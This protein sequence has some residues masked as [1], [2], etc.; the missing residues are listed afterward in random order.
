MI[1]WGANYSKTAY[2]GFSA[3]RRMMQA[4]GASLGE[5]GLAWGVDSARVR[6]NGLGRSRGAALLTQAGAGRGTRQ[7]LSSQEQSK[8][9][10]GPGFS[11]PL[12][13]VDCPRGT[14]PAA[15]APPRR[16]R[17]GCQALPPRWLRWGRRGWAVGAG[18]RSENTRHRD[19]H[20]KGRDGPDW[21]AAGAGGRGRPGGGEGP[22]PRR[23]QRAEEAGPARV[24]PAV[25]VGTV[26]GRG[27]VPVGRAGGTGLCPLCYFSCLAVLPEFM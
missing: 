23:G 27:A 17:C 12:G 5:T 25:T 1:P 15:R 2:K 14:A 19:R 8:A 10:R 24:P 20:G 11:R 13:S 16:G 21:S 6:A 9:G 3:T 4:I 18:E 22:Q 7:K 26:A